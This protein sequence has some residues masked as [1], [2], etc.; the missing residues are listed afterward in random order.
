MSE[1]I[2]SL[3]MRLIF[4]SG[5]AKS[6]AVQAM[7]AAEDNNLDAARSL[8]KKAKE[9]LHEGHAIQT[10][11]MQDEINGKEVEKSILLIHAQ[12]H[13]MAADTVIL[14]ADRIIKLY[15]QLDKEETVC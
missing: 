3:A 7:Q 6:T 8:I 12:D 15:A 14:M 2:A 9:Q 13:F 5:N 1:E 10:K 11:L 4:A